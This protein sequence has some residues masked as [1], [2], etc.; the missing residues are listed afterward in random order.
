MFTENY[1]SDM[2]VYYSGDSKQFGLLYAEHKDNRPTESVYS[3]YYSRRTKIPEILDGFP[4]DLINIIC[5]Y[6]LPESQIA[7]LIQFEKS[8]SWEENNCPLGY[9]LCEPLKVRL[10]FRC[11]CH[12]VEND[13]EAYTIFRFNHT[14]I[15]DLFDEFTRKA[16]G[17]DYDYIW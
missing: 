9:L 3:H 13:V 1:R 6:E 8:F 7:I 14:H 15:D 10:N 17:T 4:K 12:I 2:D 11:K 5:E 16:T